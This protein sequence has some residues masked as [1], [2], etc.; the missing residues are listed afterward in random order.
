MSNKD[1][2]FQDDYKYGFKDKDESIL[3]TDIGLSE[4]IVKEISR[5]K[6]EPKWMEEYRL[7]AY[8]AF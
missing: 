2:K 4:D 8:K 5:L 7:K 3:K 1:I 6:N